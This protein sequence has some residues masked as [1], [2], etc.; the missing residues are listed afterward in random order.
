MAPTSLAEEAIVATG[1]TAVI[2]GAEEVAEVIDG[3]ECEEL[4]GV[5]VSLNITTNP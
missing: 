4:V 1:E 3:E 5:L 2:R